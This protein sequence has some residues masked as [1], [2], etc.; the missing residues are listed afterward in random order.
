MLSRRSKLPIYVGFSPVKTCCVRLP[1]L[2]DRVQLLRQLAQPGDL[3][4]QLLPVIA[5]PPSLGH[6]TPVLLLAFPAHRVDCEGDEGAGRRAAG[7]GGQGGGPEGQQ[8]QSLLGRGC[9]AAPPRQPD[10]HNNNTQVTSCLEIVEQH[11]M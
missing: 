7:G 11:E 10:P 2:A 6:R 4:A 1:G 9:G 8:R 3:P 5:V